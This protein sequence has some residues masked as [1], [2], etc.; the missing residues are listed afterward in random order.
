MVTVAN[1]PGIFSK[2]R[3]KMILPSNWRR[4]TWKE[5][6]EW[7]WEYGGKTWKESSDDK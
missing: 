5:L 6:A 4:M 1:A 3:K 2:R 7:L